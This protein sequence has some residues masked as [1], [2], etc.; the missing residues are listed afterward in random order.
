MAKR[1]IGRRT[2]LGTVLIGGTALLGGAS[3]RK[4]AFVAREL[5]RNPQLADDDCGCTDGQ[6]DCGSCTSG[7]TD[8][9][10]CT[11]GQTDCGSCT[12]G[13]TDC[14]SC[15]SGETDCGSC[16]SG[17]TDHRSEGQAGGA[18]RSKRNQVRLSVH[19]DLKGRLAKII[20][21]GQA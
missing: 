7:E 21:K 19:H 9:G 12:G 2:L 3:T 11:S 20:S 18:G 16:T 8:C 5:S 14:G 1:K 17:E 4:S 10:S 6:S 15:T 13:E